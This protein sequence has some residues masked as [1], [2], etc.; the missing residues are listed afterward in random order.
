MVSDLAFRD[1]KTKEERIKTEQVLKE[2][3]EKYD[4][5]T[6]NMMS[7]DNNLLKTGLSLYSDKSSIMQVKYI[8]GNAD[9]LCNFRVKRK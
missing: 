3:L 1:S 8:G 9:K 7:G 5:F 6:K 2:K 4:I